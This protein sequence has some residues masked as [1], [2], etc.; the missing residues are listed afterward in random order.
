[1][2]LQSVWPWQNTW[3][4]WLIKRKEFWLTGVG[5]SVYDSFLWVCGKTTFHDREHKT[6]QRAYLMSKSWHTEGGERTWVLQSSLRKNPTLKPHFRSHHSN[7]IP[8]SSSARLKARP[9]ACRLC[10]RLALRQITDRMVKQEAPISFLI[11]PGTGSPRYQHVWV[12]SKAL[13][14]RLFL[15][16]HGGV[17]VC[18]CART[19]MHTV[20]FYSFLVT[21]A[22]CPSWLPLSPRLPP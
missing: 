12:L 9:L 11:I 7:V 14:P 2:L 17:C 1:M 22:A 20:R 5:V 4:D 8:S 10:L 13:P 19:H 16:D 21:R 6:Q 3:D 18:V 15:G